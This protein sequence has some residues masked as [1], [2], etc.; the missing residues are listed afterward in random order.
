MS[1]FDFRNVDLTKDINKSPNWV[2]QYLLN[3]YNINSSILD[4]GCGF[5]GLITGLKSIGYSQVYG[6]DIDEYALNVSRR[7]HMVFDAS[8]INW[9]LG[10]ENYFDI[11]IMMHVLEHIQKNNIIP[12]LKLMRSL[13][14]P[15][16]SLIVAVPNAQANTGAYWAYEDFTHEYLFTTGSLYYVMRAAGFSNLSFI[17]KDCTENMNF[18][19]K[20]IRK[21]FLG[22]YKINYEFWNQIT[23]SSFHKP[24]P[25]IFKAIATL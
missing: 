13:L 9:H 20:I 10:K 4:Y 23:S 12:H 3:K 21:F 6:A 11:I 22:L 16:G 5:G 8:N 18:P 2:N 19:K 25:K 14:K 24:S 17:D 15:Q 7:N 1:Y